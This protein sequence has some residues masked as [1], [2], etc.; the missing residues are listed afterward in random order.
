MSTTIPN[1]LRQLGYQY[2]AGFTLD[3]LKEALM[4]DGYG[5]EKIARRVKQVI[6][7]NE[8]VRQGD[9]NNYVTVYN[10]FHVKS[11]EELQELRIRPVKVE[12]DGSITYL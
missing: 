3:D 4:W 2:P 10:P 6:A 5:P 12:R 7:S 9:T 11:Y 1:I 8:I